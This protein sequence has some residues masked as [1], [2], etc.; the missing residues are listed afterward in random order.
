MVSSINELFTSV[1]ILC[2]CRLTDSHSKDFLKNRNLK[3]NDKLK[4]CIDFS[5]ISP[6]TAKMIAFHLKY[7]ID[8]I[9]AP[10]SGGPLKAQKGNLTIMA[11]GK[12]LLSISRKLFSILGKSFFMLE[13]L[14]QV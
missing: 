2:S 11:G 1:D 13:M 6:N 10:I 9:D 7:S 8:F 4:I 5:T 14:V 3:H 12:K